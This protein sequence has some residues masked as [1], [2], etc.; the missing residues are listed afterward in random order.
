MR[1]NK[2]ADPSV[3]NCYTCFWDNLQ[4]ELQA[5]ENIVLLNESAVPRT[6]NCAIP[7]PLWISCPSPSISDILQQIGKTT[8][9]SISGASKGRGGTLQQ[10][11]A[12][13]ESQ[14]LEQQTLQEKYR[15]ILRTTGLSAVYIFRFF[16]KVQWPSDTHIVY[17]LSKSS[18]HSITTTHDGIPFFI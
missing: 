7:S 9:E 10:K 4:L 5:Y 18:I 15:R 12:A 1:I 14:L 16:L 6:L 8:K 11:I 17:F 2:S 3:N 13:A